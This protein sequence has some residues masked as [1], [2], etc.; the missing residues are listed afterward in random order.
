M[1]GERH[2]LF[3]GEHLCF[4]M[5]MGLEFGI[6]NTGILGTDH[7]H[8]AIPHGKGQCLGDAGGFAP[9]RHRRQLYRCTG[10]IKL[11]NP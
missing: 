6:V 1:A 7:Q 8:A 3:G 2:H 5:E 10:H 4:G 11:L 9:R